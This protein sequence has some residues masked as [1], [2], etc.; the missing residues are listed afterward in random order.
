MERRLDRSDLIW[1]FLCGFVNCGVPGD[2]GG[3][4]S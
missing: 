4:V 2:G 3:T 1:S